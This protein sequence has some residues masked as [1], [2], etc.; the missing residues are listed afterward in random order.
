MNRKG[1]RFSA[2]ILAGLLH[3]TWMGLCP[4]QQLPADFNAESW[5]AYHAFV[6]P[7]AEELAWRNI[8][9]ESALWQAVERARREDKPLLI[10]AMN[11]HPLG[12]T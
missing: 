5:R 1:R 7:Q 6:V 10:W 8:A 4:S 2:A 9:W 3:G 12:C 11:G